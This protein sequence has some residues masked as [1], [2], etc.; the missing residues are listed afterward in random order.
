MTEH[1]ERVNVICG[2][3]DTKHFQ[4]VSLHESLQL[5]KDIKEVIGEMDGYESDNDSDGPKSNRQIGSNLANSGHLR[6]FVS[7]RTH[8]QPQIERVRRSVHNNSQPD[9]VY[10]NHEN[11]K[12]LD[13]NAS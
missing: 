4:V 8:Q 3:L 13:V 1:I 7:R 11:K 12:D 2:L 5:L 10:Q 6:Y 9:S